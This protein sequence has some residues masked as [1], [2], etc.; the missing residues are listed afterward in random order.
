MVYGSVL[1]WMPKIEK[2]DEIQENR[3]IKNKK[4]ATDDIVY[5]SDYMFSFLIF[6]L[7]Q[8]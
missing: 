6:Y 1:Y 5:N 7:S 4:K 3:K 2:E 8:Y